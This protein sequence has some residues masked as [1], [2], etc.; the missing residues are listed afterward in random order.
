MK[1]IL[2]EAHETARQVLRERRDTLDVLSARL[3]E[4]EVIEAEELKRIM[5]PLPPKNPDGTVPPDS[6]LPLAQP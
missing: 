5:G 1:R 2:A 3:L 4:I 6:T